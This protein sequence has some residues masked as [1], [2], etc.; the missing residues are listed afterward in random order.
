MNIYQSLRQK[1]G[2]PLFSPFTVLGDPDLATSKQI[3]QTLIDHGADA[4]ELGF[5]F[6]DPPADG[7]V[8]QAAH[9]RALQSRITTADCFDLLAHI[10]TLDPAIPIGLLLYY[11]LIQQYG[12]EKFYASCQQYR[13]SSI[14]IADLPLEHFSEVAPL[15]QKYQIPH[16]HIVS[17]L[18]TDERLQ[19]ILATNPAYLYL[20]SYLGVTGN[21]T[22]KPGTTSDTP[23]ASSTQATIARIRQHGSDV[24]IMVGF[25]ISSPS[26]AKN[27]ITEG[28]DGFL[29]G[30]R[31]VREI[32]DPSTTIQNLKSLTTQF[33]DA[34]K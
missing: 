33:H 3:L 8:I 31:L 5:P 17:E 27:A 32:A 28:A 10:R 1:L 34:T 22:D 25:G 19:Q 18:T 2:R 23:P 30:S 7:P 24:P 29:V 6:S 11:N 16:V 26:A 14:L 9:K 20:V 15:S 12:L 4:L 13:V 21:Q